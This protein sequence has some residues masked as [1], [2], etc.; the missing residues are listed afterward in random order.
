MELNSLVKSWLQGR[1]KLEGESLQFSGNVPESFCLKARRA[2]QWVITNAIYAPYFDIEYGTPSRVG[3]GEQ[4]LWVTDGDSYASFALLPLL[5]LL[6]SQR[7]L[8]I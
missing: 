5:T 6:T 2:Y 8:L 4:K 3:A 1:A 7:L